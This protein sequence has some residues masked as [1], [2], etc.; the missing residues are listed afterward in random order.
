MG[1]IALDERYASILHRLAILENAAV[2]SARFTAI[3]SRLGALEQG[4]GAPVS[5]SGTIPDL[6][7]SSACPPTS[8]PAS[9]LPAKQTEVTPDASPVQQRLERELIA[10]NFSTF[11][12]VRAPS[13]YYD[14][15]LEFRMGVLNAVSEQDT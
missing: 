11:K 1:A 15:P 9:D 5:S 8:S 2:V 7:P 6:Q 4:N 10:K 14:Q 13:D 12:F 3:E